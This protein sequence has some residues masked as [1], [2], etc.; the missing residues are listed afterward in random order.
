M[1]LGG[2]K[3]RGMFQRYSIVDSTDVSEA[4]A[5]LDAALA[6]PGPAKV[7]PLRRRG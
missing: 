7:A 2:W 3:A 6:T 1:T 5:K 4:L